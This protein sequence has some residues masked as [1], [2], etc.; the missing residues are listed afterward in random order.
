MHQP[1]CGAE[2]IEDYEAR[3]GIEPV[4]IDSEMIARGESALFLSVYD[5]LYFKNRKRVIEEKCDADIVDNIFKEKLNKNKPQVEKPK[6]LA[7]FQKKADI[8]DKP[9]LV[10]SRSLENAPDISD[11]QFIIALFK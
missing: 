5:R 6:G 3:F 2:S 9:V 10:T 7:A 11:K 4:V 1:F 8:I